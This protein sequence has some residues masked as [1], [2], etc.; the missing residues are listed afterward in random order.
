MKLKTEKIPVSVNWEGIADFL[1]VDVD[2]ARKMALD[3]A[4]PPAVRVGVAVVLFNESRQVLMGLRKGGHGGGTW[5]FPGGHVEFREEPEQAAIR[6]VLEETGLRLSQVHRY[7]LQQWV[8]TQF[9]PQKHY[10][11]LIFGA[12]LQDCEGDVE[13]KEPDKCER[14]EWFHPSALP[15]PLFEPIKMYPF[16]K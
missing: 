10:I 16:E 8:S 6:E 3:V 5:S 15:E 4:P 1:G 7:P 9:G 13:V 14:W 12:Y 11:T 2:T